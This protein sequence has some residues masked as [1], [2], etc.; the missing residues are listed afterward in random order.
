[1]VL[2]EQSPVD[3]IPSPVGAP[4]APY[5]DNKRIVVPTVKKRKPRP[6][7]GPRSAA[8]PIQACRGP[9]CSPAFLP[10]PW[11]LPR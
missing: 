8:E 7:K 4:F 10:I 9:P 11:L 6:T 3:L 5:T 1:M 2:Q